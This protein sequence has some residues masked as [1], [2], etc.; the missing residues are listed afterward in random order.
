M[1]KGM[2]ETPLSLRFFFE[3]RNGSHLGRIRN[4]ISSI[5]SIKFDNKHQ[6]LALNRCL[7]L[8]VQGQKKVLA[9]KDF[10]AAEKKGYRN[11]QLQNQ[12]LFFSSVTWAQIRPQAAT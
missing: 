4:C 5:Q 1:L 8:C 12:S 9:A 11:S 6:G 3:S 7:A 10:G 2:N